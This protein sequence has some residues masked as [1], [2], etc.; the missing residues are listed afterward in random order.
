MDTVTA[1]RPT[2]VDVRPLT[3]VDRCDRCGSRAYLRATLPGGTDLLFCGHHGNAHRPALLVAGAQ[4]HDETDRI[5][6]ARESSAAAA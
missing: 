3:L 4:L 6:V 2:A 1:P 5:D